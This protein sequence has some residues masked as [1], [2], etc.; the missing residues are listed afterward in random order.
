MKKKILLILLILSIFNISF[1]KIKNDDIE[2][3]INDINVNFNK[4]S[5]DKKLNDKQKKEEYNNYT[6]KIVESNWISKFILGSYY[7]TLNSKQREE[8][9]QNYKK[10]LILNY[11]P[12][13]QDFNINLEIKKITKKKENL[14]LVN[15]ITKDKNNKN[16]NVDFRLLTKENM[17]YIVDIIPEGISFI[18]SQRTEVNSTISKLGYSK[19]MENLK[20]KIEKLEK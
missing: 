1:G 19:F 6:S 7:K 17:I 16:I 8:F 18:S 9:L 20:S 2:N 11:M 4:I 15:C 13:L 10:Y 14:Y 5:T 12:K 3:F